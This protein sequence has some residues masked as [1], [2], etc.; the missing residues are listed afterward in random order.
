M[1]TDTDQ[2]HA[3]EMTSISNN[4]T[5][6]GAGILNYELDD[7]IQNSSPSPNPNFDDSGWG[8]FTEEQLEEILLSNLD[9]LYKEAVSKLV[10]FG[11]D[12]DVA[13][14]VI[15][16]GGHCCGGMDVLT[17]ILH[18]SLAYLN[19]GCGGNSGNSEESEP[20]FIDLRQL[21]EYSLVAMVCLLQ[22]LKP[23]L[24]KGEA[25]WCLLMA[26]LHVRRAGAMDIPVLPS[27]SNNECTRTGPS[28]VDSVT[29]NLVGVAP[30]LCRFNLG[31]GSGNGGASECPISGFLSHP[32]EMNL[33]RDIDC[34]KR[35]NLTPSMKSVLNRN[36]EMFAAGIRANQKQFQIQSQTCSSGFPTVDSSPASV[37]GVEVSSEPNEELPDLKN[38]DSTNSLLSKFDDLNLDNNIEYVPEDQKDEMIL[39]LINQVEDL[40]KQVK[41]QK[42]WAQQKA[43]QAAR[44]LT[45]DLIE[46][47]MLRME[48]EETQRLK[49]GKQTL[50]GATMKRLSE[51]ES[52][53]RKAS[54]QVERAN[55]AVRQ[56][57]IENAEIRAELEASKLS[58]SESL[59]TCS[60]AAK[61][62]K[63]SRKRLLSLEKQ[64]TRLQEEIAAEKQKILELQRHLVQIEAA[65]KEA[66][67]CT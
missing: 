63:K 15:L 55:A 35:F 38:Q 67:V 46:L 24:S 17:N 41:E 13:L 16:R 54:G 47:K 48:R 61:R 50:E 3:T 4:V 20:C 9:R 7:L 19:G 25:L 65:Q 36:V 28:N 59:K 30:A 40:E 52:A 5:E 58:A 45:N 51:M 29:S 42:E 2:T 12:E 18:N 27:V 43:M 11:Y 34:P 22:Q 14:G 23:H 21:V 44:K 26:D 37:S 31:W 49:K 62:E 57:E 8:Y 32:S 33:Q 39:S 66:K 64:E 60:E 1:K 10:S 6:S 56:L 53:L